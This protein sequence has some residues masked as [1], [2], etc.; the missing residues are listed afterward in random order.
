MFSSINKVYNIAIQSILHQ[1]CE[2]HTFLLL[3]WLSWAA[4]LVFSVEQSHLLAFI[5]TSCMGPT[6]PLLSARILPSYSFLKTR[7]LGKRNRP[8]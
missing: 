7:N 4:S 1:I 8:A 2:P 5:Q 6:L 3:L